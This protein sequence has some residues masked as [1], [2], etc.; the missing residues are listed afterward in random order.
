MAKNWDKEN[1]RTVSANMK[2]EDVEAFRKLAEEKNTTVGA[3]LRGFVRASIN[4]KADAESDVGT[5]PFP[6][7]Y[8]NV[9]RIN[10]EIAHHN[11]DH[12]P[13]R[14]MLDHILDRYFETAD[15]FRK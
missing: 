5:V 8:R 4:E 9:D 13:G 2:K 15:M 14:K 12:I 6:V 1:M 7:S 3:L 10:A 11:P